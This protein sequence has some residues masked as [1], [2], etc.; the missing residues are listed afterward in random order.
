M[1]LVQTQNREVVIQ[2]IKS[3]TMLLQNIQKSTSIN[4]ILSHP[5][6]NKLIIEEYNFQDDEIIAYY[7]NLLKGVIIRIDE[8]NVQLFFNY[9][10]STFPMVMRAISFY[11]H[12]EN[13]I[14]TSVRNIVLGITMIK[15]PKIR[16]YIN[17][18][19]FILFHIQFACYMKDTL[20]YIN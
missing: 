16:I 3:L 5:G 10:F 2:V 17:N 7:I 1:T 6:M 9:K 8:F 20:F 11:N 12:K 19:P 14:R 18:F 13:L 4:Y 15:N